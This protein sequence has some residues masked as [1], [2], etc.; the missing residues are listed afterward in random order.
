[1][2]HQ[3]FSTQNEGNRTRYN[4]CARPE[5]VTQQLDAN[6]L[7]IVCIGDTRDIVYALV[8]SGGKERRDQDEPKFETT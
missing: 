5:L 3:P 7:T 8:R 1:M 2:I 6:T 4:A